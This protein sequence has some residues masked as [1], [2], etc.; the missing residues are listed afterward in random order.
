MQFRGLSLPLTM[1]PQAAFL[2]FIKNIHFHLSHVQEPLVKHDCRL[3]ISCS[4]APSI[5]QDIGLCNKF[6]LLKSISTCLESLW[7]ELKK[8][9]QNLNQ[10]LKYQSHRWISKLHHHEVAN[11][12]SARSSYFWI[13]QPLPWKPISELISAT[14]IVICSRY[15]ASPS[16]GLTEKISH[17][18]DLQ[19]T[20][21]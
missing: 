14:V 18:F 17:S 8:L 9:R 3:L 2:L 13:P 10:P 20:S 21:S 15:R 1:I 11:Q 12:I 19:N 6:L 7:R 5:N 16:F 4:G